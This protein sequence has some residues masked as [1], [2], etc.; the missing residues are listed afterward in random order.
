MTRT[1][2]YSAH[3]PLVVDH[4]DVF[5]KD[6]GATLTNF[7]FYGLNT[8]GGAHG[9][10]EMTTAEFRAFKKWI[11]YLWA[12]NKTVTLSY[13]SANTGNLGPMY[14]TRLQAGADATNVSSFP[15]APDTTTVTT[16]WQKIDLTYDTSV[17][18]PS[19][20]DFCPGRSFPIRVEYSGGVYKIREYSQIEVWE[21]IAEAIREVGGSS[22]H[23]VNT[24]DTGPSM[25]VG[26]IGGY[27]IF[28]Q[29]Q[30][31]TTNHDDA[32]GFTDLGR[33][34]ED[35]VSVGVSGY[36]G[37]G[38]AGTAGDTTLDRP[39][40]I[41]TANQWNLYEMNTPTTVDMPKNL[42]YAN[43]DGSLQE[44]G[45]A[46]M[47]QYFEQAAQ[48]IAANGYTNSL[49]GSSGKLVWYIEEVGVTPSFGTPVT[50]G[51]SIINEISSGQ[52]TVNTQYTGDDY[53]TQDFPNGTYVT[54]NTY[55]LKA[56]TE[57]RFI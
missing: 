54:G 2:T 41:N 26:R 39:V 34:F 1:T 4:R 53:R 18:L 57:N 52:T 22:A 29:D 25:T 48:S 32:A 44:W 49:G 17:A 42:V 56:Y 11:R 37:P 31:P 21:L 40:A 33:V 20:F 16:T 28:R 7:D 30:I 46:G 55:G 24:N 13:N 50:V 10:R 51:S 45:L 36:S 27:A 15:G 8:K 6:T 3:R 5:L 35:T 12:R 9:L 23:F 14:D 47:Q 38:G 43:T 19:I